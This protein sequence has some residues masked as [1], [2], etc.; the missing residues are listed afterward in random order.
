MV[1]LLNDSCS[2]LSERVQKVAETGKSEDMLRY[3][4]YTCIIILHALS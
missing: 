2:A 3:A 1:H 4:M